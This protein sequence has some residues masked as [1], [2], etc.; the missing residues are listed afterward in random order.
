[1][2]QALPT[3]AAVLERNC[4]QR[5][6]TGYLDKV[7]GS[8]GHRIVLFRGGRALLDG[9]GLAYLDPAA[10]GP[11]LPSDAVTVYLGRTLPGTHPQV[12][13]GTDLVLKVLADD[14]GDLP[15]VPRDASFSGYR[16]VGDTLGATDA[17]VFIEA[18][19]VANWHVSHRFC[20][21]CGARTVP[22]HSGWMRRCTVD[23]SEHFP[24]TDPAAIVAVVGGDDRILLASNFAWDANRYSTVAGFIEA[25]ENAEQGAIREIAEEVGVHLHATHY[26]GSQAWPFPR[27]LMLGFL[28][29]THD[30]VAVPDGTEVREARWFSRGELQAAVLNGEAVIS[31]RLSIARAL[32]EHWYGSAILEPGE[33]LDH[34]EAAGHA[35]P[36]GRA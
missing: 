32:I 9:T 20:P 13:D 15:W 14:A 35:T 18:Q 25:G 36:G 22:E 11:H 21:R 28:A 8:P 7:Q 19:A 1:M 33:A 4:E 10:A 24:R 26:V 29:Y 3:P 2:I 31:R 5:S 16:D 23:G 27:S 12:P 6:E 17:A 30:T 34:E